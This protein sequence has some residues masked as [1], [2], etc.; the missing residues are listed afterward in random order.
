VKARIAG[1]EDFF[2]THNEVLTALNS[3]LVIGWR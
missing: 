2:V 1:A 3:A